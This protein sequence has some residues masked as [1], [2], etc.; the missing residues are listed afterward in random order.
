M[1]HGG[2]R[3]AAL[4]PGRADASRLY[5][6]VAGLE[7]PSTPPSSPLPAQEVDALKAWIDASAPA[8]NS[9]PWALPLV[10]QPIVPTVRSRGARNPIDAFVLQKLRANGLRPS[11]EAP[12]EALIRRATFDPTGLPPTPEEGAAFLDDRRPDAYERLIDRLLA[13][14]RYGERWARPWL[15]LARY[16]E[17]EGFK[18]DEPRPNAWRYRDDV[19][20]SLNADKPY[21]RFVRHQGKLRGLSL[22][23]LSWCFWCLGG[24][25]TH[26]SCP[27]VR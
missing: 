18:S 12:P 5:R 9:L 1:L 6:H 2:S 25:N 4:V 8:D 15:D 14:P 11:P 23:H 3:G 27:S 16:A 24:S 26:Y 20:Q 21:D 17:S 7:K 22:V 13:S 10:A 19:V